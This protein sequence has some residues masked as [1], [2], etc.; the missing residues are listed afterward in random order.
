MD[1]IDKGLHA[2]LNQNLFD[3]DY[4]L[5]EYGNQ[6]GQ[7]DNLLFHYIEKGYKEGKN[8]SKDFDTLFY[9][10]KY[11]DVKDINPLI[12]YALWGKKEH[13]FS[14]LRMELEYIQKGIVAI[15]DQN[16]FDENFYINKYGHDIGGLDPLIHYISHG[17]KEGKDPSNKFDNDFYLKFY[18]DTR[19]ENPLIHYAL[20]G[21]N[22]GYFTKKD[23]I[24]PKSDL[25]K[26][27]KIIKENNLFNHEYYLNRYP[28]VKSDGMDPLIHFINYGY[29]GNRKMSPDYD[30]EEYISKN[31]IRD[32][33]PFVHFV[34]NNDDFSKLKIKESLDKCI[35]EEIKLKLESKY[36]VS[37]IMPTY[38][39]KNVIKNAIDSVLNQTYSNFELVIIDD[40]STDGT[41]NFIK[42]VYSEYISNKKIK[43]IKTSN[44]GVSKARNIGLNNSNGDI[45]AY[46]D[47]DNI[48]DKK[49]LEKNVF[50][51][52]KYSCNTVYSAIKLIDNN[53]NISKVKEVPYDRNKLLEENFIDLN[54]FT[55][56]K[57]LYDELGG[58]DE[59]LT[60]LVDWDL[61]LKYT[62]DNEPFFIH[63]V[64][65][66]Y[67]IDF[68]LNNISSTVDLDSNRLII[69]NKYKNENPDFINHFNIAYV[70]WDFPAFS[71]TFVMNE[72]RWLVENGYN[73]KVFY[74]I[75]PDKEAD[76]D[77]DIVN[78]KITDQQDLEIKLKEFKVDIIH[79][80]FVYP[81]G[82]LLTFPVAEKLKVPFTIF[83]HAIDIF[84]KDNAG[85][86]KVADIAKS[87]YCIKILTLGDYHYD[88]LVNEG[89]P[90]DKIVLSRQ[91]TNY[92]INQF[93]K[94]TSPRFKRN[95]KNIIGIGRFVE[96]KGWDTFIE[97]ANILKNEDFIF[98]I[99]GYGPL[100]NELKDKVSK[101]GLTNVRFEGVLSGIN[102]VK[103]AYLDGDLFVSPNKIARNGDRD[104]MPTVLFEAMAYGIPLITTNIVTIP[105]FIKN[106]H[107]GFIIDSDNPKMLADKIMEVKS[108]TKER[109]FSIVNNA[110]NVVQNITSVDK[111]MNIL[112]NLWKNYRIGIF[113]VTYND[114]G[115][116]DTLSLILD[117]IYR[118]TATLFDLVVVD[119][120]SN[121]KFKGFL[122]DYSKNRD[123]MEVIL[124]E[125][126]I[127]CGPASNIALN[128]LK[129][130]YSFYI[131]SNEGFVLKPGWE[132]EA[133]N[134][135]N[136][137]DNVAIAGNL[138]SSPSFFNA[139]T[140]MRHDWFDKFRNKDYINDDIT[141][142]LKHIQG[143][144]YILRRDAYLKSGGFNTLL[145]QGHMDVEYSYFLESEGWDLGQ[146]PN[147]ISVTTK[148]LPNVYSYLD[149]NSSFAHPLVPNDLSKLD[150]IIY[151]MCN[152]CGSHLNDNICENCGSNNVIRTFYR[153]LGKS[154]KVYR[155]LK[156]SFILN[157]FNLDQSF[158]KMFDIINE[159]VTTDMIF[160][161]NVHNVNNTNGIV[162]DIELD[163]YNYEQ[164]IYRFL[165]ILENES[166]ILIKLSNNLGRN[167]NIKQIFIENGF[168][169]DI[170][171]FNSSKFDNSIFLYAYK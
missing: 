149:E 118:Y 156:C 93:V 162:S 74:K 26:A 8:P 48:W 45:I 113:M 171:K 106:N 50:V 61:I 84:L 101:L 90:K 60:R 110:Q 145:P 107:S 111:T 95:I 155:N 25:N 141:K 88:Y 157:N 81:A 4:Y 132:I 100:E 123:N 139:E 66:N 18:P 96:K 58:F 125:E 120:N 42:D 143:G 159:N 87:K 167:E 153:I 17:F 94:M 20:Y 160:N 40:G 79:T 104:G 71:Q 7:T 68:S 163:K 23:Q 130:E 69:E 38:N 75:D 72:L 36:F 124:L 56:K 136:D 144:G 161:G 103:Q 44:G 86:N 85:R 127:F 49:F 67:F 34:L 146:V 54:I 133:I 24:N 73:V 9:L 30:F 3:E 150:N 109:L 154:D 39:R 78:E 122:K 51:M 10:K 35:S 169:L 91:A 27:I 170:Y 105:E 142:P 21:R 33:N 80:H 14:N 114:D 6:I 22:Q 12:H 13:R 165:S 147:W 11:P 28:D 64:L 2:I 52:D 83:A 126:N 148:T 82:T 116:Y 47:S 119:N 70:L 37:V 152:I 158:Y 140:Y 41:E 92:K 128:H 53:K 5:K 102:E 134:F 108:L 151:G 166:F 59:N 138:V 1:Y 99:Y 76:L 65:A 32:I 15:V 19:N 98:K 46:L 97:A 55:H 117:R 57:F 115:N 135:M 168:E 89:V 131:C 112:L 129:S 63:D 137:N 164:I 43:Y 62:K 77:F 29:A 16:L 121:E 31:N